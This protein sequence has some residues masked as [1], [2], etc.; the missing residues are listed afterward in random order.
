[1][2]AMGWHGGGESCL[3]RR[4]FQTYS[5]SLRGLV[6]KESGFLIGIPVDS[7]KYWIFENCCSSDRKLMMRITHTQWCEKQLGSLNRCR[8]SELPWDFKIQW[9]CGGGQESAFLINILSWAPLLQIQYSRCLN[10]KLWEMG[11]SFSLRDDIFSW[12]DHCY[13]L[14]DLLFLHLT[15]KWWIFRIL[16]GWIS[17]EPGCDHWKHIS[18]LWFSW[19][20]YEGEDC[21]G[22]GVDPWLTDRPWPWLGSD[23]LIYM[24]LRCISISPVPTILS[25]DI[26][27]G[28]YTLW[29][30]L[31]P[32]CIMAEFSYQTPQETGTC[33]W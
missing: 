2:W 18:S 26:D 10:I 31:S 9:V 15:E 33:S 21:E 25:S 17:P 5:G 30:F 22:L 12:S 13:S 29:C 20:W 16:C 27:G 23:A 3:L 19:L 24:H 14:V 6:L 1:M 11:T 7:Y 32:S 8:F 28:N 4:R